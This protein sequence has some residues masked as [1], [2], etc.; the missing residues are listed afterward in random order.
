MR[1]D[2]EGR[3]LCRLSAGY[4]HK[5]A[6]G[7]MAAVLNDPKATFGP[8]GKTGGVPFLTPRMVAKCYA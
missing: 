4:G 5:D 2:P 3:E 6:C 8:S 7:R 1:T